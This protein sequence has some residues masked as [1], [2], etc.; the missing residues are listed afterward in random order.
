MKTE[1]NSVTSLSEETFREQ[2]PA[3][4]LLKDPDKFTRSDV[5]D[6]NKIE[7]L[8]DLNQ[9]TLAGQPHYLENFQ[10]DCG[11]LLT[12]Y[13]FVLTGLVDAGH[14]KSFILHTFV[15]NK[16]VINTP[17]QVRCSNCGR[18]TTRAVNYG[19]ST[20]YFCGS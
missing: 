8:L 15:G 17:R 18:I 10:C 6:L 20:N 12:M 14:S 5:D 3:N 13:D 16:F 2:V 11:R 4:S 7:R 1:Y 9:G 19:C